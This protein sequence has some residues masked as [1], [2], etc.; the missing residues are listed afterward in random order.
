MKQHTNRANFQAGIRNNAHIH[1]LDMPSPVGHGWTEEKGTMVAALKAKVLL[2]TH[3]GEITWFA[4]KCAKGAD[5][6]QCENIQVSKIVDGFSDD[7]QWD[8]RED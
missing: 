2:A 1:F 3:V 6:D 4:P 5:E 8:S 7:D